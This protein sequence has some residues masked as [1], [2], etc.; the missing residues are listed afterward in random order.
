M[1]LVR[2]NGSRPTLKGHCY[3]YFQL[4]GSGNR[5]CSGYTSGNS[6]ALLCKSFYRA[7]GLGTDSKN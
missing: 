2:W 7:R 4:K 6:F 3:L 1:N 5:G